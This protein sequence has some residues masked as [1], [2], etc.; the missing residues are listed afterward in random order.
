M[1]AHVASTPA[2]GRLTPTRA[3]TF[4]RSECGIVVLALAVVALHVA[5]D[6]FV[7]RAPGTSAG[8][9]LASGLVPLA[10][11][12]A[13]AA[14]YPRLRAAFRAGLAMTLGAVGIA[15]G[16]PGAYYLLHGSASGDHYS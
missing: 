2:A 5:D 13:A 3:A 4:A 6:N 14:L 8:D 12:V 15:F 9:H 10:V 16:V 1:G 7:Q 11:L